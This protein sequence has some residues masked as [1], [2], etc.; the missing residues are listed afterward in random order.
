MAYGSLDFNSNCL[1]R[2]V[3][4]RII[5][6]ND[7]DQNVNEPLKLLI[8]LHGYNGINGDWMLNSRV[9]Q[10]ASSHHICVVMPSGENS[11]YLDGTATGRQYASFV[12]EELPAYIRKTFP[13]SKKKKFGEEI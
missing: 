13:V 3:S 12:G 11:F 9:L 7:D 6:P 8:L 5:L 10:L 1:K 2:I 4:F